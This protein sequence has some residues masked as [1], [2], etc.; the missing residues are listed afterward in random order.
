[1]I[2]Q[3]SRRSPWPAALLIV[4]LAALLYGC[5]LSFGYVWD[6]SL[7]FLDKTALLN[8]PLS[9]SLLAEPVLPGTTYMRPLVFL[10]LF[11]E[12]HL[13]GQSPVISH[14]VNLAL[15]MANALLVFAVCR[16]LALSTGREHGNERALLAAV[17]YILHPALV[18]STAWVSGRFDLMVTLF[19]L[20][21]VAAYLAPGLRSGWR[22]VL[23]SAAMLAALLSKELGAVLPGVLLCVWVACHADPAEPPLRTFGRMFRCNAGLLL[24]LA[25]V[26]AGYMLLRVRS[27]GAAYHYALNT[28]Y[29]RQAWIEQLLPLEALKFYAM[30]I[31]LPFHAVG[32]LHPA[33]ELHP[34]DFASL[35]ASLFVLGGLLALLVL[36]WLKRTAATWL[37]LAGLLCL[38]PVMHFVPLFIGGN[39]G[40]ERFLT[41]P[42]AFLA[43][44]VVLVRWE[45]L[46]V[47]WSLSAQAGRRILALAGLGWAVLAAWTTHGI[48]PFWANELQLWNWA[49]HA[50]PNFKYARYNYLYGALKESRLHLVDKEIER[51]QKEQSGLD[52]D[53]QLLY[54]NAL[55]RSGNEESLKYLEGIMFALP[56][57]HE[58]AD[59]RERIDHFLLT[60]MQMGGVYADY[61]SALMVFRGEAAEALKYNRIAEWYLRESEKIPVRYQRVAI[62]Y[63]LGDFSAADVLYH[64]QELFYYPRKDAMRLG[65]VQILSRYCEIKGAADVACWEAAKRGLIPATDG[66]PRPSASN[67]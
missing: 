55:V 32:P 3:W 42:L 48:L 61:A 44:A 12:F 2:S 60:A 64:Q 10:T 13:F 31:L 19:L 40:H 21:G 57:F 50:H 45:V 17:L 5:I 38:L 59:G 33:N 7:L 8:E 4:V 26:L 63:A 16:R 36:A 58:Q 9:W 47:R 54:A 49:Y 41:A 28:D 39:I 11:G 23:V 1:M 14:S 18:E 53:V 6:D 30:Q 56:K 62:L 25:A 46:F 66:A 51:L 34:H 24:V 29:V 52:V 65:V 22:L 20:L 35:S 15:L 27:M 67:G 43:M 37:A